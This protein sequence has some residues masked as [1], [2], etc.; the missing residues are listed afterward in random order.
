[1]GYELGSRLGGN[2]RDSLVQLVLMLLEDSSAQVYRSALKFA[3][4][5]VYV[6]PSDVWPKY[7]PNILK[8]FSS[9]HMTTA[10]MLVRRIVEKMIKTL[11]FDVLKDAFPRQHIPL[12]LYLQKA[13]EKRQ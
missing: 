5:V 11:H 4:V 1:M 13:M 8:L 12:L 6:I 2:L 10:K 9:P 7:L 3:K